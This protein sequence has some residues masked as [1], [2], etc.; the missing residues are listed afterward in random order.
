MYAA[1]VLVLIGIGGAAFVLTRPKPEPVVVVKAPAV[2]PAVVTPPV[3]TPSVPE[4][5]ILVDSEPVGAEILRDGARLGDTPQNIT[6]VGGKDET[7]VMRKAGYV[8]ATVLL[9]HDGDLRRIVR[10]VKDS[11]PKQPV[12]KQPVGKQPVGKQPVGKSTVD[13]S[14]DPPP[15]I[16]PPLIPGPPQKHT[17]H[18]TS[19]PKAQPGSDIINPY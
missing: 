7:I 11:A 4:V 8:N 15:V 2:T 3:T 14:M 9:R 1:V 13:T 18:P 19:K 5:T 10:L 16:A 12:G 6:L 17:T